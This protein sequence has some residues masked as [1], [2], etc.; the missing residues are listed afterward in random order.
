MSLVESRVHWRKTSKCTC[1]LLKSYVSV[2]SG[3]VGL[4]YGPPIR[5]LHFDSN[6]KA[7]Q[8]RG[9]YYDFSRKDLQLSPSAKSSTSSLAKSFEVILSE[10]KTPTLVHKPRQALA[11][12]PICEINTSNYHH[13]TLTHHNPP[14]EL[15][16]AR[17]GERNGDREDKL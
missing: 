17:R 6:D 8:C 1:A 14:P 12:M 10:R 15:C 11:P 2:S 9:F 3:S 4:L 16:K 13:F 7:S 5:D